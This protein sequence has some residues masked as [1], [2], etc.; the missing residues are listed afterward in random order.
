MASANGPPP[1]RIR[2]A[3]SAEPPMQF[4]LV[5]LA[6]EPYLDFDYPSFHVLGFLLYEIANAGFSCHQLPVAPLPV[7][8]P[9]PNDEE[10]SK[11]GDG[12]V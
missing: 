10:L 7:D 11:D 9:P 6:D 12:P 4:V 5:S 3:P 1:E 8:V 2:Q